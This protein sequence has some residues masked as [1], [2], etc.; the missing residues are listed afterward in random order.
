M[1]KAF[2]I[3][4]LLITAS[5]FAQSAAEKLQNGILVVR[6]HD[7]ESRIQYLRDRGAERA[8]DSIQG[9]VN[10]QHDEIRAAFD[11]AYSFT[12]VY[13]IH[14]KDS[15]EL[16]DSNWTG[17]LTDVQG[18]PVEL[19]AGPYLLAEFSTTR[20]AALKGLVI[21]DW[22]GTEWVH[23]RHFPYYTSMYG[24]LHIQK[25]TIAEMVQE[26]NSHFVKRE[27]D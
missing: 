11:T 5:T 14:S 22:N 27:E 3:L 9:I 13:F 26:F 2:S 25:A 19:A 20:K 4:L 21:W 23:P 24:F 1:K 6:L 12:P 18:N 8:A 16:A 15:R 7:Q 10:A 17:I